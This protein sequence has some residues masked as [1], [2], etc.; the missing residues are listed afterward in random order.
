[1]FIGAEVRPA[2]SFNAAQA[3]L[4]NLGRGGLLY[5][6]S[7]KAYRD[8]D[9]GLARV[10][11]LGAAP[12]KRTFWTRS[13]H[14]VLTAQAAIPRTTL[15]DWAATYDLRSTNAE[16]IGPGMFPSPSWPW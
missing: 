8:L 7:D 3:R 14:T 12:G 6:V 1:M 2:V 5:R 4:A 9:S 15:P 13:R 16:Q 11:P 10:G